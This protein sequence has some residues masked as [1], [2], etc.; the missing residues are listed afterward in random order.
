MNDI[1]YILSQILLFGWW[2]AHFG[3]GEH[4]LYREDEK[5]E[6]V[7]WLFGNTLLYSNKNERKEFESIDW[8]I[9]FLKEV[10]GDTY[11]LF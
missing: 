6:V 10:K 2:I 3:G 4:Y 9:K 11:N 8:I 7:Q 1:I 5:I